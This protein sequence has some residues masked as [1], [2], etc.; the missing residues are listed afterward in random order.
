MKE[1]DDAAREKYLEAFG[2]HRHR[3]GY[4]F[5]YFCREELLIDRKGGGCPVPFV[6]NRAQK[7]V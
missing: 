3:C 7:Y 2:R 1:P 5:E 4:D 6:L